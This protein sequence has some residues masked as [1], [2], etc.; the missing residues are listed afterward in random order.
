MRNHRSVIPT[1]QW[2]VCG[3]DAL[4]PERKQDTMMKTTASATINAV[5][6]SGL[7]HFLVVRPRTNHIVFLC[8]GFLLF[9]TV[10]AR[11]PCV[12]YCDD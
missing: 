8:Y 7:C 11:V 2:R 1:K 5:L 10:I 12:H 9:K 6:E 3:K 4:L